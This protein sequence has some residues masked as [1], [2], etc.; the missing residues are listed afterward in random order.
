VDP[1]MAN[2]TEVQRQRER[3]KG[4]WRE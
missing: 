4:T 3:E 2:P 1:R